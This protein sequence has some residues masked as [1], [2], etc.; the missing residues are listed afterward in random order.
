MKFT[1]LPIT[2][3]WL[4]ELEKLTDNRGYFARGYDVHEF[5]AH[6]I[7]F[8]FVQTNL[9]G[10]IHAGTIRGLHFQAAPFG[11]AKMLRCISGEV[12]DVIVDLRP[13]SPTFKQW[14][15]VKV[16]AAEGQMVLLPA[17][18][19]HGYQALTDGAEVL[20]ST[21]A[22][23]S[24]S[25]ERGIRWNDPAFAIAWPISTNVIVS[26]K[27]QHWPDFAKDSK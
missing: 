4:I 14:I 18:C 13:E 16:S 26:E 21:S 15:G 9:S 6:G 11:E 5:A 24:P 27:D 25:A 1:R 17:Y 22:P 19:A 3:A 10:C 8:S 20:Y 2:G 12:F 7:D 23:Y